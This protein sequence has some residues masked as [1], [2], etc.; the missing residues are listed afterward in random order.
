MDHGIDHNDLVQLW[1]WQD[2]RYACGEL[3]DADEAEVDHDHGCCPGRKS[4]GKCTRGLL[5]PAC[6][7][8]LGQHESRG[9]SRP[10]W[11][12]AY[13]ARYRA[14]GEYTRIDTRTRAEKIGDAH[15]S[16]PESSE[17]RARLSAAHRG[18]PQPWNYRVA[19]CRRGHER[20]AENTRS[21]SDSPSRRCL[22][23]RRAKRKVV[24]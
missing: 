1:D 16:V 10:P 19:V 5:H 11:A 12:H 20:T 8:W 21:R 18:R 14:R 17:T 6:N 4:C 22:D 9:R 13:L 23:C 15:R 7:S 3:I 24:A 2:G